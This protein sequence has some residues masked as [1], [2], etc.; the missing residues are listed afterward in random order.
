MNDMVDVHGNQIDTIYFDRIDIRNHGSMVAH[1]GRKQSILRGNVLR[2]Y[3]G[4]LLESTNL[5]V[6]V[7][8]LT[9]DVMGALRADH[10]G[11]DP[12]G[13]SLQWDTSLYIT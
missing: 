10:L 11:Y 1:N 13:K 7:E 8:N 5:L 12:M 4:A 6:Q 3:P 9:V 2:I